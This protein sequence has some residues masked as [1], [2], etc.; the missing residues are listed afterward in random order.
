ME[1]IKIVRQL[2][3]LDGAARETK[4]ASAIAP[5][6]QLAKRVSELKTLRKGWY[7]PETP[8]PDARTID[9]LAQFAAIASTS[10]GLA[11]PFLYA[12]LDGGAQAEWPLTNWEV[13]A[14]VTPGAITI[15][16]QASSLTKRSSRRIDVPL[17]DVN[18]ASTAFAKFVASLDIHQ[19]ANHAGRS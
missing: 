17:A 16:L 9:H 6:T 18:A 2:P 8:A 4:V 19:E 10:A 13:V 3:S 7:E 1:T 5:V 12:T 11:E 14:R 15:A